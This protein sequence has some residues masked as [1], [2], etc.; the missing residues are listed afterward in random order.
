MAQNTGDHVKKN[1]VL[2]ECIQLFE[3]DLWANL[4]E[5]Y[6]DM[7]QFTKRWNWNEFSNIKGTSQ[8]DC[9]Y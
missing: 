3:G 5:K 4:Y 7:V 8:N 2:S 1:I 6:A 9:S